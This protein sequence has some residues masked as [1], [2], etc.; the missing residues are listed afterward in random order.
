[1]YLRFLGVSF[2]K[3]GVVPTIALLTYYII[4]ITP[5]SEHGFNSSK[6]IK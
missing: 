4:N 2:Y 5:V 6:I 1:M 3:N